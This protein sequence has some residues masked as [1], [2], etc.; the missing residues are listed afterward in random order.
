MT[1]PISWVP[2]RHVEPHGSS[3]GKKYD[4]ADLVIKNTVTEHVLLLDESLPEDE[5][6]NDAE[7][8]I[9]HQGALDPDEQLCNVV[10]DHHELPDAD[11]HYVWRYEAAINSHTLTKEDE[12]V[13]NAGYVAAITGFIAARMETYRLKYPDKTLYC[14][15]DWIVSDAAPIR[16]G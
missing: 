13:V 10:T 9:T 11:V 6:W 1:Q 15:I 8:L 14:D 3:R 7:G 4:F 12:R 5:R 16:V 2:E